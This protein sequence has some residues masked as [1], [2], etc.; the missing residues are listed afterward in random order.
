MATL[1]ARK[2]RTAKLAKLINRTLVTYDYKVCELA[3]ELKV[4]ASRLSHWKAG[5]YSPQSDAEYERI[6]AHLNFLLTKVT[7]QTSISE[8]VELPLVTPEVTARI[9]RI[10]A[11]PTRFLRACSCCTGV[12]L[13]LIS[14][15]K[16]GGIIQWTGF[17][18]EHIRK[19]LLLARMRATNSPG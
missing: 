17:I 18:L 6:L 2:R 3:D 16:N 8:Q 5:R 14:C 15:N 1:A 19:T 7:D 11:E 13:L 12:P 4:E 10:S 9:A